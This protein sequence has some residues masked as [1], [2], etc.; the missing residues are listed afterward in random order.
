M[1]QLLEGWVST[2]ICLSDLYRWILPHGRSASSPGLAGSRISLS[3]MPTLHP[4]SIKMLVP[5][6]HPV[7]L[8]YLRA[9]TYLSWSLNITYIA[10]PTPLCADKA[11]I[12]HFYLPI[13][14][15]THF[16]SH[17]LWSKPNQLLFLP[18]LHTLSSL[19]IFPYALLLPGTPL[20]SL[21]TC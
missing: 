20:F 13:L 12:C 21:S 14:I 9:P 17:A 16:L 3:L 2:S 5:Y 11:S 19:Y 6:Q 8:G 15:S 4:H 7:P 1:F 18:E 10:K